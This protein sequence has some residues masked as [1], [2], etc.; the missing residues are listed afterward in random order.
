MGRLPALLGTA[1]NKLKRVELANQLMF[2]TRGQP[3]TYYG[4]EQ[5]FIGAGGDKDARQDMFATKTK[6]YA[7][8]ANLYGSAGESGAK[9]RYATDTDLY[10]LIKELSKLRS[11]HPT[12]AD[13]AQISRYADAGPGDLRVQPD[14]PAG[15]AGV[16]RGGEQ[17][18]QD[19]VRPTSTPTAPRCCT[20]R[21]TGPTPPCRRAGTAG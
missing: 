11:K 15:R 2:L 20:G 19:R 13:G 10:L 21:S 12:L 3:V 17:L 5:G 9:N 1:D 14:Q 4:D 8:E 16:P 18:R 6:Q 7:D